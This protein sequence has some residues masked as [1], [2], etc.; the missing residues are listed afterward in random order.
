MIYIFMYAECDQSRAL[1]PRP[2]GRARKPII[3]AFPER[4]RVP[5]LRAISRVAACCCSTAEAM[6]VK[7]RFTIAV[8][9]GLFFR[10][11]EYNTFGIL[12]V[13]KAFAEANPALV[14][15]V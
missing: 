6:A 13:R 12:N 7:I 9:R 5:P 4:L 10:T 1:F 14:T 11:P 2:P 15:R 8:R 3:V